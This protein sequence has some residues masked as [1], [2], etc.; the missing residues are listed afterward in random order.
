VGEGALAFWILQLSDLH[1]GVK[2]H[3][4]QHDAIQAASISFDEIRQAL[5]TVPIVERFDVVLLSGDFSWGP[6]FQDA[7]QYRLGFDTSL[8]LV[9]LLLDH[10]YCDAKGLMVLPGNHDVR[11]S[12]T[13]G[14]P[15]HP[16]QQAEK[17]Y[18][19][20][21]QALFP[22]NARHLRDDHAHQE[23]FRKKGEARDYLFLTLNSSRIEARERGG[24][25]YVGYSQIH[26]LLL[27]AAKNAGRENRPYL[28]I[29]AL[30]HHLLPIEAVRLKAML[31]TAADRKVSFVTDGIEVLDALLDCGFSLALH[32]HLHMP[33]HYV[34]SEPG[35]DSLLNLPGAPEIVQNPV[36]LAVSCAGSFALGT[37]SRN[38]VHPHQFQA[39]EINDYFIRFHS[40]EAALR[41]PGRERDWKHRL[42]QFPLP[43][44]VNRND[45]NS[46]A[47]YIWQLAATRMN[48][49][50]VHRSLDDFKVFEESLKLEA[51]RAGD[52]TVRAELLTAVESQ[53]HRLTDR[54]RAARNAAFAYAVTRITEPA[55]VEWFHAGFERDDPWSLIERLIWWMNEWPG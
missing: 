30:H 8:Q 12:P 42:I 15:L 23:L 18:R 21:I 35:R 26:S 47:A 27:E 17:S 53:I 37:Q 4:Y 40:F 44:T 55:E 16:R 5:S 24:T 32:G 22:G 51:L 39:I 28:G 29:A 9:K 36:S 49:A 20:F 6:A 54:A 7:A 38:I 50:R 3:W 19:E 11:W 25:G 1:F 2:S 52:A 31:S 41:D 10:Q 14:G 13:A 43:E 46:H 45:A 33:F 48:E 34:Y